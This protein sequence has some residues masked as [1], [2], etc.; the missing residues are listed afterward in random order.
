MV[1]LFRRW[2]GNQGAPPGWSVGF[3][4]R[5]AQKGMMLEYRVAREK[6]EDWKLKEAWGDPVT[7]S[8]VHR[9]TAPKRRSP[10]FQKSRQQHQPHED[11]TSCP[12]SAGLLFCHGREKANERE[13][14]RKRKRA[15]RLGGIHAPKGRAWPTGVRSGGR[16]QGVRG[17]Q[18][19][20][21]FF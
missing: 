9:E 14:A 3:R 2:K 18:R 10:K 19:R 1:W 12:I 17:A 7:S 16:E 5:G 20:M 21:A 11:P 13:I 4:V 8:K 6:A 15:A